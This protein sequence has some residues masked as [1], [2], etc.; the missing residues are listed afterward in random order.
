M[1][2]DTGFLHT[3]FLDRMWLGVIYKTL[4]LATSKTASSFKHKTTNIKCKSK[5]SVQVSR[6]VLAIVN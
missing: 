5:W 2:V 3:N 4:H 1:W 6:C